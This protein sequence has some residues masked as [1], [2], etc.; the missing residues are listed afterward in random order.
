[1]LFYVFSETL[2]LFGGRSFLGMGYFTLIKVRPHA[3]RDRDE[4]RRDEKDTETETIP[5]LSI[6]RVALVERFFGLGQGSFFV[7]Q[8]SLKSHNVFRF[9]PA[10][11]ES[12]LNYVED[13]SAC[14]VTSARFSTLP[15]HSVR[16]GFK[17]T[18]T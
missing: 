18:F 14:Q 8:F 6:C 12:F 7:L 3:H 13:F 15:V 2:F 4:T 10:C 9:F 1:M 16:S 5:R 11:E 17:P